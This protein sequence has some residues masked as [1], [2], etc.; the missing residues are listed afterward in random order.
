ML[1]VNALVALFSAMMLGRYG[2]RAILFVAPRSIRVTGDPAAQP[3]ASGQIA[4][5]E[6]LER[7]GFRRLGIRSERGPLGGLRMDVDAWS[8][9]D[10]TCADAYPAGGRDAVVSF[11]T[12]FADGYQVGTSNFRR[13][14]VESGAGRVGGLAGAAVAGALAAHRKATEPLAAS[15]GSPAAVED[16]DAR[17]ALANRFYAGIGAR[18]LRRPAFMSLVNTA[19]ALVLLVSSVKLALRG[20][21]LLR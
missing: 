9:P 1:F 5:G 21:G 20:L 8:H 2:P 13:A 16:L 14:A 19:V 3:R 4:A 18:E 12:T 15:H 7:L 10:G 6:L 17:I 11:L